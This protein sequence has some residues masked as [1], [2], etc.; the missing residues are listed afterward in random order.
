LAPRHAGVVL[1]VSLCCELSCRGIVE[2]KLTVLY[3]VYQL[4]VD[5]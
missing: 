3:P 5:A 1:A 4:L 2:A